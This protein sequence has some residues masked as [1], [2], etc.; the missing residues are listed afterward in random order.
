MKTCNSLFNDLKGMAGPSTAHAGKPLLFA[1][2]VFCCA[3][4]LGQ[5]NSLDNVLRQSNGWV[6]IEGR[7]ITNRLVTLE[8][9]ENLAQ[10]TPVAVLDHRF[11]DI[12]RYEI[13][14]TNDR[15]FY[16]DAAASA[17]D[18]R[19]YRARTSPFAPEN[20]WK[21]QVAFPDDL[22]ANAPSGGSD[23]IRWIKFI[24]PENEP[25]RV[26][27]QDSSSYLLHYDFATAR[28]ASFKGMSQAAFDAVT[29]YRTN[30]KALLGTVILP[31]DDTPEYGI[32]F[33]SQAPLPR[34]TV[35][36]AF[37]LVQASIAAP[38]GVSA[39]YF[40]AYEQM[41][42]A[43]MDEAGLANHGIRLGTINRW[44]HSSQVYASGWALGVLKWIPS[45][46]INAAYSS[47]RLSP[48]DIL[49][50]DGIPAEVPFVAGILTTAPAT[51]NSHVAILAGSYGVPFAY[52]ASGR[53]LELARQNIDREIVLEAG[54]KLGSGQVL[55]IPAQNYLSDDLKTEILALKRP[56]EVRIQ[57]KA[58]AGKFSASTDGLLL[59]D[60]RYFG[61]KAAQYGILRRTLPDNS[62]PA[63]AFSFD[64][65]DDFMSQTLDNGKTLG[66][67]IRGRLSAY[68][69]PPNLDS[70]KADLSAIREI[71]TGT[72]RFSDTQ[73]AAITN[74]LAIFDPG[75]KIR[76]RSSSNAEDNL[77]FS[78]AG[79][80]D[81]YSGCLADDLDA[82]EAGPCQCD[83]GEPKERGVFRAVQKVY[84]SFYND[85]AFLERLRHGIDESQAGMAILAHYS[86][87]DDVELANG[88]ATVAMEQTT[89]GPPQKKATLVSQA[90]AVSVTNPSGN[91]RPEVTVCDAFGGTSLQQPSTLVPLG[92]HVLDW[93]ADYESLAGMLFKVYDRYVLEANDP[94]QTASLLLDCEYK[95]TAPGR[96]ILKQVR[97][98]PPPATNVDSR[99]M[100]AERADYWVYQSEHS[101]VFANHRLKCRLTLQSRSGRLNDD[102]WGRCFYSDALL[103]YHDGSGIT[104]LRG[105]PATWTNAS[106][107]ATLDPRKGMV[108]TDAWSVGAG[109]N[110]WQ[111]E[112]TSLAPQS[113]MPGSPF[114][115]QSE[116][117]KWLSVRY[118]VPIPGDTNG[119]TQE[120]I[121]LIL[122]PEVNGLKP[123]S[124]DKF[125]PRPALQFEISFLLGAAGD[126]PPV[127]VDPNAWGYYPAAL[128]PWAHT[129]ITGLTAKPIVLSGY[130]SQSAAPT[131]KNL[132]SYYFFE[133]SR[134]ANIDPDILKELGEKNIRSIYVERDMFRTRQVD[135]YLQGFDGVFRKY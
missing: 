50:T 58:R 110:R 108:V 124:I 93:T 118:A 120:E 99:Y 103:E 62:L 71:I 111:F 96:L 112:L 126:G 81:S 14:S 1:L 25:F 135:V 56:P 95:K 9:S 105:D 43:S 57:P 40:P 67:E 115:P 37:E 76:F 54:F 2:I 88:V 98:L 34:E 125:G 61:G 83:P 59:S 5:Q 23:S 119:T 22:F 104:T 69:Y 87:P 80:Y 123:G 134:E 36:Q 64:L 46:E 97:T 55:V 66:A 72:A 73:K 19:F 101:S 60:I 21:N 90:G 11:L 13:V 39:L 16:L 7:T 129:T 70:L 78:A 116:I 52:L 10:W 32:Q 91:A 45:N 20:D 27:F 75:K 17:L 74:A 42:T 85:N 30:S 12:S 8:A 63:V 100:L 107:S 65:W 18:R 31:A 28:L 113:L 82:D 35:Q 53:T 33:S 77:S 86:T 6:R 68:A 26:Y 3:V 102:F 44:V 49:F 132:M 130:Y 109:T 127:G 51:P 4:A 94:A 121:Q 106:H 131:H 79:L 29:L 38:S 92:S 114:V 24:I 122:A 89:F 15:F 133:P 41:A 128:S 47:G 117:R 48:K 84:A